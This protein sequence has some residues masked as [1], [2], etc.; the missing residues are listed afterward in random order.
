VRIATW[1][2]NSIVARLPLVLQWLDQAR[3]DVLCLQEIKCV[4]Q[5]FP[6]DFAELGYETALYGQPTYN[7][8]ALISRH[9][10]EDVVRGLPDDPDEDAPARAIAGTVGGIRILNVYIP[11]GASVE[12]DKY[13]FKLEWMSRLRRYLDGAFDVSRDVLLCGDFNVAPEPKD[14][15]DPKRWEGSVLFSEPERHALENIRDWGFEDA[16]RLKTGESG[17]YSWWDYRMG[18]FR[19]NAG[20][21]I[22]HIWVSRTLGA[23]CTEVSIDKE[24]RAWERPSDH[25]PVVA[26]FEPR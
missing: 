18:A 24:T 7:G 26:E 3:P 11:N 13:V 15:H 4:A 8:V 21:R 22:D 19:R 20:L 12:S 6:S 5:R 2:V 25:A 10:I 1:N 17:H 16:F 23:R 9:P 14:V